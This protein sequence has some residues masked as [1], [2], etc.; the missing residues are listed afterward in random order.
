MAR[1]LNQILEPVRRHFETNP[2][3]KKLLDQ[4]KKFKVSGRQEGRQGMGMEGWLTE[5]GVHVGSVAGV[6][7]CQVTK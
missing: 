1:A 2:E 4:V 5:H 6:C 3:A 7:V